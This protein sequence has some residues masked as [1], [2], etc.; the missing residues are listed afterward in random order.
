MNLIQKKFG[1]DP[2]LS[3]I[4]ISP[5]YYMGNKRRLIGAG[6]VSRFPKNINTFYDVF[7]GSGVVS[8]NTQAKR[9]VLNDIDPHIVDL[10]TLFRDYSPEEIIQRV[11]DNIETYG[12]PR[13]QTKRYIYPDLDKIA[14]YK[15]AYVKL[16]DKYNST[17][18]LIDFYTLMIFSFSQQVRFN[19]DGDFNMPFGNDCF[20]N[21]TAQYIKY[22]CKF[23]TRDNL[24]L[25]S[26]NFTTILRDT[27]FAQDDFLYFDPPYY[28]TLAVY[29]ERGDNQW[30]EDKELD[31]YRWL[32]T[33]NQQGIRWGL[34]N[35][36]SNKGVQN[37]ILCKWLDI[38]DYNVHH[39]KGHTYTACGK[40]N[41]QADEV[42][43]TNYKIH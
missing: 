7:G 9:Y 40:G 35:V 13:E 27:D 37:D 23:F 12:L 26:E 33:L 19:S 6:L 15:A 24:T 3:N 14:E 8:M 2:S 38:N 41:S 39:F 20:S 29:N 36:V 34:S 42:F 30:G 4:R 28:I 32:D 10:Y 17:R 21:D 11:N 43:I 1:L 5:I 25:C 31:L 16:R 18:N 22:G